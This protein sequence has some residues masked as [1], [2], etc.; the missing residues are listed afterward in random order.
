MADAENT[1]TVEIIAFP[2]LNPDEAAQALASPLGIPPERA[3]EQIERL[4]AVVK[5]NLP[6]AG[7]QQF[8][9]SLLGAGADVRLTHNP[10]GQAKVYEARS[11]VQEKVEASAARMSQPPPPADAPSRRCVSCSYQVPAGDESCPRCGWNP[12]RQQRHCTQCKGLIKPGMTTVI[13]SPAVG[14]TI[15]IVA[16]VVVGAGAFYVG[17]RLGL[18][19]A[20]A[21]VGA[22]FAVA[23]AV[24]A[25]SLN[26]SCED[27]HRSARAAFLGSEER[28]GLWSR[29]IVCI[30]LAVAGLAL[31]VG[32]GL[33]FINRQVLE[34]VSERGVYTA[35][36]PRTHRDIEQDSMNVHT[37]LGRMKADTLAAINKRHDVAL[38]T[39]FH[40]VL[41]DAVILD[42]PVKEHEL[43]RYV[44]EGAIGNVGC[45][46][47]DTRDMIHYGAPG[48]EATFSGTYQGES[49]N[50]RARVYL[51]PG[52]I[53]M[54]LYAGHDP[55]VVDHP[56]GRRF[57]ETFRFTPTP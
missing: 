39:M 12:A 42:D 15:G 43:L 20:G 56:A 40:F 23:F 35:Q 36:L 10:T 34:H 27:C 46:M 17:Y 5:T 19:A 24:I 32:L 28:V 18:L 11:V 57:F 41:P 9:R 48:L 29:R 25:A 30:V 21:L 37:P 3:A 45:E 7:A 13:K 22:F 8:V 1:F 51:F 16:N 38:F 53:A 6:A 33:P 2:D 50:G 26:V 55:S 49:V 44:M 4:P 47:L 52:E 14:R 31:A 54:L